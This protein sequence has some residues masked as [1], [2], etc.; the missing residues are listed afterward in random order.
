MSCTCY[1]CA[2]VSWNIREDAEAIAGRWLRRV[3]LRVFRAGIDAPYR[4][5]L[6]ATQ[7]LVPVALVW[8]AS[9]K[10]HSG[11]TERAGFRK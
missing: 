1:S 3:K 9:R 11:G 5:D 2:T 8:R 6:I 10:V 7:L 4:R